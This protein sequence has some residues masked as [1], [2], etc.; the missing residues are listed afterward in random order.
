MPGLGALAEAVGESL[1]GGVA[2]G[3]GGRGGTAALQVTQLRLQ[4]R[5]GVAQYA[6]QRDAEGK[7]NGVEQSGWGEPERGTRT[8]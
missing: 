7:V 3:V 1:L 5:G 4:E 2:A 6:F 8:R